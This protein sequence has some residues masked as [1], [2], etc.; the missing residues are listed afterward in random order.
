MNVY[1]IQLLDQLVDPAIEWADHDVSIKVLLH[2]FDPNKSPTMITI[3]VIIGLI[4]DLICIVDSTVKLM[5]RDDLTVDS[6]SWMNLTH[7]I[8]LIITTDLSNIW[9]I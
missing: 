1:V 3:I 6:T 7:L 8:R 4:K 2:P 5:F 9:N